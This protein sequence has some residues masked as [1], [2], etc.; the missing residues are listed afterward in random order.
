M[1]H[2]KWFTL[3]AALC[4]LILFSFSTATFGQS[5]TKPIELKVTSWTPPQL[6]IAKLTEEWGRKVEEQSGGQVKLVFYWAGALASYRDHYRVAQTGVADICNWVFGN[7]AGLHTLNEFTSL[8]LIGW[9]NIYTATKVYHEMRK[10]FP[11]LDGEFKG[12]RNIYTTAMAPNQFHF[13]KK[14]VK[15]IED[16]RGMRI[17]G[18]SSWADF[19]KSLNAVV[20]AKGPPDWYMSLQ[21]GLVDGHFTHWPAFDGFKL[22]ELASSHTEAGDAGFGLNMYGWWINEKS[23]NKLPKEAQKAFIDLQPWVEQEDLKLNTKLIDHARAQ[24]EKM[25]HPIVKLTPEER[26][27]FAQVVLPIHKKWIADQ[28]AKGLPG[29]AVY[30]EAKKLIAQY[31]K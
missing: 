2:Y 8:P 21:K 9:D 18:G 27:R 25:G 14:T 13:T 20:V 28:E 11:E 31:T 6:P 16:M 15:T 17:M 22:E 19:M 10:K 24:A 30:E 12:L 1:K 29:K 5:Q 4:V 3:C 7:I 26:E 23:W